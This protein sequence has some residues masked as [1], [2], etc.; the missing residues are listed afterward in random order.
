[1]LP[2][3]MSSPFFTIVI[4]ALNEEKFLPSLLKDLSKQALRDFEV[5][6][7]DAES[8]DQTVA[9]A[10]QFTDSL[11]K[12]IILSTSRHNVSYSRNLGAKNASGKYLI[13]IDADS[14]LPSYFLSGL[15]YRLE[16]HRTD[17]FT[18]WCQS[19]D[20]DA[21][22]KATANTMNIFI[23]TSLLLDSP[24]ALGALIGI[25]RS[26]FSKTKGF[27]T[28]VTFAED[29]EFVNRVYKLGHNFK[30]FRDPRFVYSMRRFKRTGALKIFTQYVNLHFKRLIGADIDQEKEYPMGGIVP[31]EDKSAKN[32]MEKIIS[33]LD[34]GKKIP[35]IVKKI[36]AIAT[37]SEE[38]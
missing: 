28:K 30:V 16:S 3:T 29:A 38:D 9:K 23:E 31:I 10:K 37:L 18:C 32:L 11:P 15:H 2:M 14:R 25:K 4:P 20:K 13:F 36:K 19:D 24:A 5:I 7:V 12:L 26:I 22:N 33:T 6:L 17:M 35:A 21:V 1:M 27:D 34:A 8:K